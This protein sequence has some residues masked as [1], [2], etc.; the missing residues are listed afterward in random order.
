MG[1][2]EL[3]VGKWNAN[4]AF[5]RS[6]RTA[7]TL[8]FTPTRETSILAKLQLNHLEGGVWH[9]CSS[10]FTFDAPSQS[11]RSIIHSAPQ[12]A[13]LSI[14][15]VSYDGK[16][17]YTELRLLGAMLRRSVVWESTWTAPF[18]SKARTQNSSPV[19]PAMLE[20]WSPKEIVLGQNESL[21]Y[22]ESNDIPSDINSDITIAKLENSMPDDFIVI[23]LSLRRGDT[24]NF[25]DRT[26][27]SGT[28]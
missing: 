3:S 15:D 1:N 12:H 6:E 26:K 14:A 22:V 13:V 27:V 10:T 5:V 9:K 28:E 20:R 19:L 24:T 17:W 7:G 2:D 18:A 11:S 8:R 4:D 23:T 16:E 21:V 25:V